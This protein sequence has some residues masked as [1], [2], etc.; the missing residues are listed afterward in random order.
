MGGVWGVLKREPPEAGMLL[1]VHAEVVLGVP[2]R[3]VEPT[4]GLV[5]EVREGAA[6]LSVPLV[7][8]TGHGRTWEEAH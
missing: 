2:E 7:V 6:R 5:A 4:G 8:E 1:R 3:L